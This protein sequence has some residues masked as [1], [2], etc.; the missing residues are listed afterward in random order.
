MPILAR[1]DARPPR[2]SRPVPG[3]DG[4]GEADGGQAPGVFH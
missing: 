1:L 4:E 3:R 2:L